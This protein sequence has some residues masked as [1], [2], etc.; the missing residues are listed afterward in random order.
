MPKASLDEIDTHFWLTRSVARC[1]GVSLSDAMAQGKITSDD[2]ARIVGRCLAS[3][4][5][6]KCQV[7]LAKQQS[8]A[9]SAPDFCANAK[10]L[11]DLR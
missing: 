11:N 1:M 2:Y 3:D 4:C 5:G 6:E 10:V 8:R 7:W 9:K